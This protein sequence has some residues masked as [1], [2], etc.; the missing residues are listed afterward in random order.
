ME[1]NLDLQGI[2]LV[3]LTQVRQFFYPWLFDWDNA[4]LFPVGCIF[5]TLLQVGCTSKR[6]EKSYC[7]Q[8]VPNTSWCPWAGSFDVSRG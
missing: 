6:T 1:R 2:E 7:I 5:E 8:N 4:G 3:R